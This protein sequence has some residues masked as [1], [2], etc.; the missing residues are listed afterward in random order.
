MKITESEG[1]E[2]RF[3]FILNP[4]LNCSGLNKYIDP[5]TKNQEPRQNKP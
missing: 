1:I 4:T 3:D 2:Q 5:R